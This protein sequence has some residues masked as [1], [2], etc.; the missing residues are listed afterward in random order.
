[1]LLC[2]TLEPQNP[3]TLKTPAQCPE[4]A[5]DGHGPARAVEQRRQGAGGLPGARRDVLR[6]LHHDDAHQSGRPGQAPRHVRSGRST[7]IALE[8]LFLN[9][10]KPVSTPPAPSA[11][12]RVLRALSRIAVLLLAQVSH[13]MFRFLGVNP[14]GP[15]TQTSQ[16]KRLDT[17][18]RGAKHSCSS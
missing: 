1:M 6:A 3:K 13:L 14:K 18:A 15:A 8:F 2:E 12:T 11:W 10:T 5:D 7:S 17:S 9:P 16:A 4:D